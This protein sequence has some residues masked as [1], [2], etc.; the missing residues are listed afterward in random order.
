MGRNKTIK[1]PLDYDPNYYKVDK[2]TMY[3]MGKR[4]TLAEIFAKHNKEK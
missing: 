2:K 3:D 1:K 4:T